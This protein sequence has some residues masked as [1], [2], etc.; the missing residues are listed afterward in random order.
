MDALPTS[1]AWKAYQAAQTQRD[2]ANRELEAAMH[3]FGETETEGNALE[4]RR[5]K[6]RAQIASARLELSYAEWELSQVGGNH[7]EPSKN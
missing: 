4:L 5:A 7:P 1:D 2:T 6:L 3:A